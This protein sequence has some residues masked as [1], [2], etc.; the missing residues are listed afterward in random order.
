LPP[1]AFLQA[2]RDGEAALV[3]AATEWLAGAPVVADLFAGLGTFAFALAGKTGAPAPKVLAVEAAR[4]AHLAC[5]S[6]AR[7]QGRPV[8]ALHRDLFRNPL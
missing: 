8:T 7:G 4:D 1:G 5:Q 3:A 2:T 6:A